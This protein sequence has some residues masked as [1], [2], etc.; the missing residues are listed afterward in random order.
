[1]RGYDRTM[2][3]I[4]HILV[5]DDDK[6]ILSLLTTFFRKHAYP[7]T[8]APDGAAMFDA[9][10]AHPIDLVILDVMLQ[11]E[12]GFSLCRR[13]RMASKIPVIML[14]AMADLTERIVG[15]EIGADDYLVKP[16]D[17]RELLAR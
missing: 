17:A 14:T 3:A 10:E 15:L 13:L 16:F 4:P 9:L 12:D 5:V 1:M 11:G 7:V 2:N 8:V 6:D